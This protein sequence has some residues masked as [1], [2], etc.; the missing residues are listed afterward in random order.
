MFLEGR[1]VLHI[2]DEATHF[3]VATFLK[4]QTTDEIWKAI[5][6]LWMHTYMGPPDFLAVDQVSAYVS[7][8]FKANGAAAGISLKEA[9]IESASTIGVAERYPAPLHSAYLKVIQALPRSEAGNEEC[10]K[11]AL[12]GVNSSMGPEGLVS[13][14]LVF[15]VLP[16]PA[17]STPA[18]SQLLRQEAIESA[19]TAATHEQAKR[20]VAFAL[21]HPSGPKGKE[22][23]ATLKQLP[24][25]SRVLLYITNAKK[26]KGLYQ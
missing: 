26:W 13:M 25:G 3:A 2:V 19:R 16:R 20:R 21:R 23:K 17:R 1:S 5:T 6:L 18:A 12:F 9:P 8:K 11:L 14:L 4:T 22:V 7:S 15:E 10:L 24:P